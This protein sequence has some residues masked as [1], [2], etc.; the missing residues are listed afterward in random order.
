MIADILLYTLIISAPYLQ[1]TILQDK[2]KLPRLYKFLYKWKLQMA[3][4]NKHIDIHFK[5]HYKV[6]DY[7]VKQPQTR[8]PDITPT[9]YGYRKWVRRKK[10]RRLCITKH[11]SLTTSHI[12]MIEARTTTK[13]QV[14]RLFFDTDSFPILVDNCC[15]RS[16]TNNIKDFIDPPRDTMTKINGYNGLSNKPLQVGTVKWPI[17][18]DKGKVHDF[19]LPNTYYAPDAETRL[20]SP[21]HWAQTLN[22]GRQTNC[23]TYH[24]A[25]I[26]Q[27]ENGRYKKTI[28]ISQRTNNVD[29]M[30]TAPGITAYNN[31]CKH[32]STSH[33][34]LAYPTTIELPDV[35][36][37][38]D[39]EA[40]NLLMD[41]PTKA[42]K[43]QESSKIQGPRAAHDSETAHEQPIQVTYK[44]PEYKDTPDLPTYNDE[45]QEYM[46]WHYKLNHASLST[47]Q[48]MAQRKLL[49]HFITKILRKI[50]KTGGKAP[51]CNDCYSASACK[52]QWRYK[53]EKKMNTSRKA[54]LEPGDIVSVDQIET[55]VPGFLAQI[56]GS[57]TRNRIVGSS[58]YVDHASDLSY[59]HHHTSMSSEETL[60][61]KEAFEQYAKSHG[62]TIKHY[63]AD[64]GRFK[65]KL[66]MNSIE[67]NKQTI[68]F[69][70]VGA[71]HQNGVAEKRIGDLQRKAT[72]LLLHAQRRWPDAISIYLWPYALRAANDSR[73]SFPNKASLECPISR[74]SRTDR[75]PKMRNQHHFGCPVYVLKKELQDGKKAKKWTDRTRIGI[76]LGN[77][78]RHAQNVSLVL[79]LETGL[80]S[81]Q[82]HCHHD[83]L[84][85]TMTGSQARSIPK[86]KWQI[87]AGLEANEEEDMEEM[88]ELAIAEETSDEENENESSK[89]SSKEVIDDEPPEEEEVYQTRSGRRVKKP[90]RLNLIAYESILEPYD[91]EQED[92]WCEEDL[93]TFKASTDPDTMY[94]HQVMR[95][96][97]REKF[98]EAIKKEC[99]DHFRE[100]NYKLVDIKEVPKD[101]PLLS[102]VWQMKRKRK[103]STGEISKYKA[104][105]NVNGKEQVKGIHYDET[106]APVV[107]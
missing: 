54:N 65:D 106:Y 75:V 60:K 95:E 39:D 20:F 37:I 59:I 21:Q 85:E 25:T 40:D 80:V 84:F 3:R 4:L 81:P 38:T 31:Y 15:S 30:T 73:N 55:S 63:H 46:K 78:P 52:T 104:R 10:A 50:E 49:P 13:R 87:K 62:V 23:I 67:K 79:N 16:I 51:M 64:N 92:E 5:T 93:M 42:T 70:G 101:A 11:K 58:V 97:D 77:S 18:D 91:Y 47:M 36:I 9:P 27:W 68:S 33:P 89:A 28:P 1:T 83:D 6:V 7:N 34:D 71:H 96:P 24:D 74:F 82:F 103:P 102:S 69:S 99:E 107:G 2:R 8:V 66:F 26:L 44:E 32:I 88:R 45:K 41:H 22:N 100:S 105:M 57:L 12:P 98:Q 72:A 86:S 53:T 17:R 43:I 61:G 56:T 29:L 35:P 48:R 90:D 94:Y 76:H 14:R 19:L